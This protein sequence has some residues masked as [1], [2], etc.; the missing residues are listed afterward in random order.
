MEIVRGL[1]AGNNQQWMDKASKS[2]RKHVF[3]AKDADGRQVRVQSFTRLEF[4]DGS[5]KEGTKRYD[6]SGRPHL[7]VLFFADAEAMADMGLEH[8][9]FAT[10]PDDFSDHLKGYVDGSQMDR[11]GGGESKWPI[12]HGPS[13]VHN[14][15]GIL[16]LKHTE[17]DHDA[18]M[19]AFC[20]D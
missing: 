7:H 14:D 17:Q 8:H 4:Q 19:R 12:Y 6:G 2:W 5:R 9:L 10:K 20:A 13:G 18:G 3:S 11:H 1:L 16:E 15:D